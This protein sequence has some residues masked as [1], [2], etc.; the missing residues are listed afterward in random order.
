M[1]RTLGVERTRAKTRS[2]GMRRVL[3]ALCASPLLLAGCTDRDT[4]GPVPPVYTIIPSAT[5]STPAPAPTSATATAPTQ[6]PHRADCVAGTEEATVRPNEVVG[7]VCLLLGA[8]L[9]VTAAPSPDRPWQPLSSSDPAVLSCSSM[10][11]PN[12]TVAG[13]CTALK[14][15]SVTVSSRTGTEAGGSG[16]RW[17]LTLTIVA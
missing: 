3:A 1:H 15:G 10:A 13:T 14:V 6:V 11:G 9:N 7:P 17:L 12:G 16:E 4:G 2:A 5:S 8:T